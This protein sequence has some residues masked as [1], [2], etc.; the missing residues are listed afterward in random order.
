MGKST[1]CELRRKKANKL[2]FV[3]N[4]VGIAFHKA[5]VE[6]IGI[7]PFK[8]G[9]ILILDTLNIILYSCFSRMGSQF[10]CESFLTS[11]TK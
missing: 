5:M 8:A 6:I 3:D 11:A 4:Y 2:D 9:L 1:I 7:M 10:I